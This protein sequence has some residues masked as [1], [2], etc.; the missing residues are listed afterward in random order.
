MR[1]FNILFAFAFVLLTSCF[2][3]EVDYVGYQPSSKGGIHIIGAVEDYDVKS[4]GTRAEGDDIADSYI[5]EMTMFIFKDKNNNNN[6]EDKDN[7]KFELI[8]GYSDAGRTQA[9]TSAINIQRGNPTFLI[10]TEEGILADLSGSTNSS[11]VFYDNTTGDLTSCH[12]YIVA[13]A[14]DQLILKDDKGNRHIDN[15]K[16]LADLEAFVYNVDSTLAMPMIDEDS[17]RGFPMIGKQQGNS[18]NLHKEGNNDNNSVATIPLKKLYSKVCFTMQI[19]ADQ[20][21]AG[22]TPSFKIEKVEVF[23]VP[24]KVRMGRKLDAN[25]KPVYGDTNADDYLMEMGVA[26]TTTPGE[27][28]HFTAEPFTIDKFNKRTISHSTSLTTDDVIEFGFYMPEHKVTPNPIQLPSTMTP[29]EKAKYAQYYKPTGVGAVRNGDGSISAAKIATFVRIHG[30]YTDHNGQIL[31]VKYDIYLGQNNYD[32][33]TVK[34]NQ[35]LNNKLIITGLT[36][37][38]N[39]Y[40]DAEHEGNISIDHRVEVSD[41]GFNLS[42]ERTAILD[43][44]FEV[45]PLD[46]EL[47][48]DASMTVTIPEA[49]RGWVAM[50]DDAAARSGKNS[51]LYV[52]T[53]TERKGVRKYFTEN[54]VSELNNLG[55]YKDGNGGTLFF[56]NTTKET[57]TFRVWFYIDENPNVYDKTGATS[58][59]GGAGGYTVSKAQYRVCPVQFVYNGTKVVKDDA[60]G[61][62]ETVAVTKTETINFQ[63]WN[64]W[65]V[66]SA[67]NANGVR[68]RFYDIE[69]EEEYLNN[70]ASDLQYGQTQNGMK[71]GLNGVQLSRRIQ[72]IKIEESTGFINFING[73]GKYLGWDLNGMYTNVIQGMNNAK[74]YDF[75]LTRDG[76]ILSGSEKAEDYKRDYSGLIFNE[77]IATTLK[78]NYAAQQTEHNEEKGYLAQ[79]EKLNLTQSPSSAFAYCYHKN[80]RNSSGVVE[81]QKWFLPA[82]DEIEDIALGAYDEFDRVFQN[83]KYWSCQPAYDKNRLSMNVMVLSWNPGD[84][85]ADFYSDDLDRA[86]ATSVYTTDGVN[87]QNIDSGVPGYAGTQ[88]GTV[89]WT[90]P[91]FGNYSSNTLDFS[92]YPGNLPRTE[93]CRIR[94]VYRSGTK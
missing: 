8:Q 44:H 57:K 69:H 47:Q 17:F 78:G 1:H 60:T 25:G 51:S 32:D 5:S 40:P 12:I 67:P 15:I 20:V 7:N 35:Q 28:Y 86:R 10:D 71:W 82:I 30:S 90:T 42:M 27:Y 73:V 72:A 64:L 31:G 70:Y 48:A 87:Y 19:N 62:D 3:D 45:R 58:P 76:W 33:F 39:A 79:I 89:N 80:K 18:F 94:A 65:R 29:E 83:K 93:S 91:S 92:D 55:T 16:T 81:E 46:I 14:W 77:E 68:E 2:T 21:V 11:E 9:C 52:N 38:K 49:Y 75:Y 37:H 34:R 41:R 85:L 53:S 4:V 74:H 50:E 63:Q 13:N 88:G 56:E 43:A 23:N 36:N 6:L 84:V 26:S 66:W 24:N 54:L 59:N 22:Q 61:E